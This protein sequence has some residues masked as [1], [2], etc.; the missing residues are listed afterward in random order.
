VGLRDIVD[1]QCGFKFFHRQA[2]LDIFGRQRID[3]Y[4]FDVEILHLAQRAGY[5]IAQVPIRWR[6]DGD[7]RL[8]VVRGNLQNVIDLFRIRFGR[9][10]QPVLTRAADRIETKA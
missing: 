6:D 7:S 5:P 10:R 9:V 1:T 8:A 4:M 3:G 2:A